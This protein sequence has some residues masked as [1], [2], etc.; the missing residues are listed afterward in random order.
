MWLNV[1]TRAVIAPAA[2]RAY[3]VWAGT[4]FAAAIIFGGTGMRPGDLTGLA[5]GDPPVGAALSLIWLLVFVP[6]A[7][8]LVRGDGARY[9]ASLPSP[10]AWPTVLA[11]AAL[12]GLQLPWLALWVLGEGVTGL[13]VVCAL[14]LPIALIAAWRPRPGRRI[15][16]R[17]RSG[18]AALR[19]VFARALRRRAADALLRGAGLAILAGALAGLLVHNNE[20]DGTGAATLATAAIAIILVAAQVGVR[21]VLL[22][23]HRQSAWLAAST[24][25]PETTR[26]VA[27]ACA[28]GGV[29]LVAAAIAVLAAALVGGLDAA[30]LG[31]LALSALLAAVAGAVG[32]TRALVRAADSP[33]VATRVVT[34]AAVTAGI[35]VL[36]LG[37]VGYVGI[38]GAL[39]TVSV[40]AV[41]K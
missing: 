22:E 23:A 39:A 2:R 26:V 35:T 13:L 31:W 10:R 18:G 36:W 12:V 8:G 1:W 21:L 34:G 16:A 29:D 9:L 33:N 4:M 19:G 24:G 30:T 17:W 15:G 7:R 14:T 27:L 41:R 3:G 37:V 11:S 25:V 6:V 28:I 5:I 38:A 20:L 40:L 32:G